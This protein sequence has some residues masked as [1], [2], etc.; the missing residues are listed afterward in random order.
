MSVTQLNKSDFLTKDSPNYLFITLPEFLKD[1]N[2]EE[3]MYTMLMLTKKSSLAF[4][5]LT[6]AAGYDNIMPNSKFQIPAFRDQ[7]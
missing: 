6:P 1:K 5:K 4:Q 3:W 2:F 7:W